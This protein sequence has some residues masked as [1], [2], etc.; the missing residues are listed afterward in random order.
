MAYPLFGNRGRLKYPTLLA[1]SPKRVALCLS[2]VSVVMVLNSRPARSGV[3]ELDL[4]TVED[5]PYLLSRH[6]LYPFFSV[7][8][9]R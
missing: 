4:T 6:S 8:A 2:I 1:L 7:S 5:F 3:G 9:S